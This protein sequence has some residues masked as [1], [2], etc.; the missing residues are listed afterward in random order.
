MAD[1]TKFNLDSA[2]H[3]GSRTDCHSNNNKPS[4]IENQ[5]IHFRQ[6]VEELTKVKGLTEEEAFAV[7]KAR[8]NGS[9]Y[10]NSN[11]REVNDENYHFQ[12]IIF[13]FT[14]VLICFITFYLIVLSSELYFLVL[15][16]F[17]NTSTALNIEKLS[18]FIKA[19]YIII[20]GIMFILFLLDDIAVNLLNKIRFNLSVAFI[21]IALLMV[22]IFTENVLL[23]KAL[24]IIRDNEVNK[25]ILYKSLE[26]IRYYYASILTIGFL[27]LNHRYTKKTFAPTIK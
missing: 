15:T 14:G 19:T 2:L 9:N 1:T 20:I 13:L 17:N 6:S 10:L 12:K 3:N 24:N 27:I 7:L 21:L 25:G 23:E 18:E 22:M 11:N 26:K 4:N 8:F 16:H 5:L